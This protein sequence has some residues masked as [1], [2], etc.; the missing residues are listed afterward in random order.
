MGPAQ[1]VEDLVERIRLGE[2][3][4]EDELVKLYYPRVYAIALTR[5]SNREV[6]RDVAQ[7]VLLSVLCSLRDGKLR[8]SAALPGYVCAITRHRIADEFRGSRAEELSNPGVE[9]ALAEES[10]PETAFEKAERLGLALAA[11]EHLS[12]ADQKILRLTLV[13]GLTPAEIAARLGLS[14]EVVR[15]RKSRAV[16]RA[17]ERMRKKLSREER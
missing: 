17:R 6:A 3:P 5:T 9:K 4:A 16:R 15:K 1:T 13:E 11:I 8:V 10:T 2:R 7:E 12:F 14:S